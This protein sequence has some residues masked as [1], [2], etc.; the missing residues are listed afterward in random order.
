MLAVVTVV[1][2]S[3]KPAWAQDEIRF[4]NNKKQEEQQKQ[5]EELKEGGNTRRK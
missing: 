4:L 2:I 5:E 3:S 1:G